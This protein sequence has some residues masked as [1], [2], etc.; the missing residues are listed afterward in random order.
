MLAA[1]A[2]GLPVSEIEA[3]FHISR[4]S[5]NRWAERTRSDVGLAPTPKSGRPRKLPRSDGPDLVAMVRAHADMTLPGY[6]DLWAAEHGVRVSPAT[7]SRRLSEAGITRKK[8]RSSRGSRT[9]PNG[10]PGGS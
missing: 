10:P 8:R 3:K 9:R 6:G 1:R 5:L 4:R 2:E 7:M